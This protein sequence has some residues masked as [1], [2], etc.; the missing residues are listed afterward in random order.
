MCNLDGWMNNVII[1]IVDLQRRSNSILLSI[2]YYTQ[3]LFF[4]S[5]TKTTTNYQTKHTQITNFN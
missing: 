2:Y 4:A 3:K 5:S 1:D